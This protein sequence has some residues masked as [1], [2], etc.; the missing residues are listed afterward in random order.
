MKVVMTLES[1]NMAENQKQVSEKIS[2]REPK[3]DQRARI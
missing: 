1:G 3:T 2:Y